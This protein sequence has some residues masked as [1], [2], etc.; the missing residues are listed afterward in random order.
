M[1]RPFFSFHKKN[2]ENKTLIKG[3]HSGADL[4]LLCSEYLKAK[5]CMV[6]YQIDFG[7]NTV[8]HL[9]PLLR[10][11]NLQSWSL[12]SV[13]KR[14]YLLAG[15][16]IGLNWILI[17]GF[18][19]P[20]VWIAFGFNLCNTNLGTHFQ[21]SYWYQMIHNSKKYKKAM[22]FQNWKYSNLK[23]LFTWRET[24]KFSKD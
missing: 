13:L 5:I 19:Y 9:L 12:I 20:K 7:L 14:N 21:Y 23:V 11:L 6:F 24:I 16:K 15:E 8:S 17:F 1:V 2:F 18:K 4:M 22:Y 10:I 3:L